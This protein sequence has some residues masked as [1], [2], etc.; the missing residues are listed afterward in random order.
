MG[1]ALEDRRSYHQWCGLAV[2][3]DV[4]GDR[5]TLL[6][7]R[8]LL[9]GP[10]RFADLAAAQPG[11]GPNLLSQ[12]LT[13]LLEAGLVVTKPVPDDRRSHVYELTDRGEALRPAVLE[14][15]KWGLSKAGAKPAKGLAMAR[16]GRLAVQAMT[17]DKR[18]AAREV[19]EFDID[20]E[21]FYVSTLD[22]TAEVTTEPPTQP[23]AVV[24][25]ADAETF[26]SIGSGWTDAMEAID[27]DKITISGDLTA[28]IRCV[29]LLGLDS[30]AVAT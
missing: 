4:L 20:D 3:L 10:C 8:E 17:K 26:I 23:P 7:I 18:S 25:S 15:A 28:V 19:Y 22:G 1:V 21:R 9:L 30:A 2:A 24:M 6:L 29:H 11:L 13:M 14:L 5:W 16:W 12:R 27:A